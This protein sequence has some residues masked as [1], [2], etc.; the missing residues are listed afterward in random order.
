MQRVRDYLNFAISFAGLGYVV[1]WPVTSPDFDGH[2]FGIAILC[3]DGAAGLLARL[4]D[5]S[6]AVTLPPLLHVLGFVAALIVIARVFFYVLRRSRQMSGNPEVDT[7]AV[8]ERRPGTLTAMWRKPPHRL[9]PVKPRAQ[10]GL[11]G[12]QR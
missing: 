11:R 5:S 12:A 3:R 6:H 10:F 7:S 2:R 8:I 1:V 4:C 9:R